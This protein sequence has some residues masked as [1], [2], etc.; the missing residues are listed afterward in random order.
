LK[1]KP[2]ARGGVAYPNS[3]PKESNALKR[4]LFPR[5]LKKR[6]SNALQRTP[7]DKTGFP[8]VRGGGTCAT[9]KKKKKGGHNW[10]GRLR[11]GKFGKPP[12]RG[13]TTDRRT[14]LWTARK[15]RRAKKSSGRS[16]GKGKKN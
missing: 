12:P 11:R 7:S 8:R 4:E 9:L 6:K 15:R 3:V 13:D 16:S 14:P 5:Q 1:W 2:E 10:I